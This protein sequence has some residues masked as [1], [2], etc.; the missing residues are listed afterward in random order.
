[1]STRSAYAWYD[2]TSSDSRVDAASTTTD[3][4][5]RWD[6]VQRLARNDLQEVV[7]AHHAQITALVEALRRRGAAIA[8]MTGSGS[9]V[10]GIVEEASTWPADIARDAT[11]DVLVVRT[12]TLTRVVPVELID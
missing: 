12:H 10:F 5:R 8:Q 6:R 3:E 7:A 4:L 11:D 2:E 9:A 1:M